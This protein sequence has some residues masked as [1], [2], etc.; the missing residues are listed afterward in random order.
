MELKLYPVM[1]S[2]YRGISILLA[3]FFKGAIFENSNSFAEIFRMA[4]VQ[5]VHFAHGH[6]T[7]TATFII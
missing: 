1:F 6:K 5:M 2:R 4:S 3:Q 7:I